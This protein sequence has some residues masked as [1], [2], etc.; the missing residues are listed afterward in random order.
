MRDDPRRYALEHAHYD[1]DLDFWRREARERGGPVLDL[2]CAVGRV[3]IP[4]ARDGAEVWALDSS[5]GMLAELAAQLR[6]EPPEVAR[7]LHPVLADMRD[8]R[9][10]PRFALVIA[11]MNTLQTLLVSDDQLACLRAIRAH[12]APEGELLF[13][14]AVPDPAEIQGTLGLVRR[15]GRHHDAARDVTLLHSAWYESFDPISQTLR[16]A[17]QVDEIAADGR[18][19]RY[20][21]HHVVHLFYP[22]ELRHLLARSGLDVLEVAGDF[23][24]SPVGAGSER[25]VYRCRA[26]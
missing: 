8:F 14:V 18:V 23:D 22:T 4:L 25:Q 19:S 2:G 20:L 16:F 13:D 15:T 7:R 26:A 6:A 17:I 1:E 11:A 24:G 12:L 5:P 9:L 21:R 3:A 10:E